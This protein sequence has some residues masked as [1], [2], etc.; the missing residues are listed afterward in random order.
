MFHRLA[1]AKIRNR[2]APSLDS[3]HIP[4]IMTDRC[5][6]CVPQAPAIHDQ[7]IIYELK[8]Q[9][10]FLPPHT[11][12]GTLRRAERWPGNVKFH[13]VVVL[14]LNLRSCLRLDNS[15]GPTT[16]SRYQGSDNISCIRRDI[17][18]TVN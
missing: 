1:G 3:M 17:V 11:G 13:S 8:F 12:D 10:Q 6:P 5:L 9:M 14:R 4:F 15:I 7:S 16:L 2:L 18:G